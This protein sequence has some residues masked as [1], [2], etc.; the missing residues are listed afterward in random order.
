M[1]LWVLP[2]R[3][4]RALT[5]LFN[6][7]AAAHAHDGDAELPLPEA[8]GALVASG[9]ARVRV[10]RSEGPWF[11]LTHPRDRETVVR[12]LQQLAADGRYPSPLWT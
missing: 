3:L 6:R 7:F 8:I 1:N 5:M 4:V 12:A 11:G 2:E 9:T 10:E